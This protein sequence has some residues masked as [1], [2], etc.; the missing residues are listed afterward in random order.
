M[1]DLTSYVNGFMKKLQKLVM[2]NNEY[3]SVEP[4]F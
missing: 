1:S 3:L 2:E 4:R